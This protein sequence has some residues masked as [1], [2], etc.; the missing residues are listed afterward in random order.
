MKAQIRC[1]QNRYTA[2]QIDL[3][4]PLDIINVAAADPKIFLCIS[5]LAKEAAAVNP[6]GISPLLANGFSMFFI[7]GKQTFINGLKSIPRTPSQGVKITLD[8][9]T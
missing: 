8:H 3:K 6:K 4:Y 1:T 7:N 5:T 2:V 9:Q